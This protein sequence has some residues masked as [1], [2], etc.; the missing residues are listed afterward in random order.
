MYYKQLQNG[1]GDHAVRVFYR[2]CCLSY[3]REKDKLQTTL[4]FRSQGLF[5]E[6]NYYFYSRLSWKIG[7]TK[8]VPVI[9]YPSIYIIQTL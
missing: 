2:N 4:F 3:L 9:F 8:S 5:Y 6:R 1:N 7:R